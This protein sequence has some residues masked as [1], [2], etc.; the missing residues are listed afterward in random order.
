MIPDPLLKAIQA[1]RCLLFIGAGFSKNAEMPNGLTMPSWNELAIGLSK[2]LREKSNE[3][4]IAA[5]NYAKEFGTNELIRKLSELLH[6]YAAKPG[7]VH[8]KLTTIVAFDTIVTTNFESLLE[9]AFFNKKP[10]HVIAGDEHIGKYSPSTH[11]NII[12][13]HGDFTHHRDIVITQEDYENFLDRHPVLATNLAAW[14]STKTPLFIGYSL[15]DSHFQQLRH[16]LKKQLRDFMNKGYIVLF[17]A[18]EKKINEYENDDLIVINLKTKDTTREKVLLEFLCQIQDYVSIRDTDYAELPTKEHIQK[19]T[20]FLGSGENYDIQTGKIVNAF[21]EFE[22]TLRDALRNYGIEE[23]RL[24]RSFSYLVKTA[25]QNGILDPNNVGELTRIRGIRNKIVHTK[26]NPTS[27]EV[28][29][30]TTMIKDAYKQ[31]SQIKHL[32]ELTTIKLF[33]NKTTYDENT[34]IIITGNVNPRLPNVPVS[35]R[36]VNSKNQAVAIFQVDVD[37]SWDFKAEHTP[38]GPLWNHSENYTILA[39]CGNAKNQQSVKITFI[40]K[41]V[42]KLLSNIIQLDDE[43]YDLSY[44]IN[45]GD[46]KNILPDHD[47]NSLIFKIS[48]ISRGELFVTLPRSLID[49]KR[50]SQD[51][52]FIVLADGDETLIDER[53]FDDHR[54]L[55]IEFPENTTEIEII[56][57]QLGG[58]T[59][60]SSNIVRPLNGSGAPRDDGKYLDPQTLIIKKGQKIVFLN[61]DTVAHTFTA[62]TAEGGPSGEFDTGL[63]MP[64]NSFEYVPDKAGVIHYFCMVHPWKVGKIIVK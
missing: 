55:S 12:K 49:S 51:E 17:D 14:L 33:T 23:N 64:G 54:T 48:A 9:D 15:S 41:N 43:S 18:D 21:S 58:K 42:S 4:L 38:E 63:L 37:T 20:E 36:I 61:T 19:D 60:Q 32:D 50:N 59:I 2:D 1:K 11:T 29:Y 30:V 22:D 8:C 45:G 47:S 6:V 34:P 5:S 44:L 57:S 40:K 53:R 31:I 27:N 62:E 7:K 3:P 26:Y 56:G 16:I 28:D 10:I 13:I 52:E 39:T 25:A 24:N 46:L 35:L